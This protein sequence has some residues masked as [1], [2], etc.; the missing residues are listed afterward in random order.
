MVKYRDFISYLT[1]NGCHLLRQGANHEI[2][3]NGSLQTSVPRH[4]KINKL[5]CWAIC[6]QLRLKKYPVR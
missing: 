1:D 5:T 3:S 4:P 2:W 6:K